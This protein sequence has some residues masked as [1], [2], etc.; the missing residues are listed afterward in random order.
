M[1][2]R[3]RQLLGLERDCGCGKGQ[4]FTMH[5][6]AA[7][8]VGGDASTHQVSGLPRHM[9]T[10]LMLGA[11]AAAV[12]TVAGGRLMRYDADHRS[13]HTVPVRR[14]QRSAPP[15]QDSTPRYP[16]R[17]PVGSAFE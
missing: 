15:A 5:P 13:P 12:Q 7:G 1:I 14:E 8:V 4:T 6:P 16:G 3:L 17:P 10:G 2:A 11:E 9:R